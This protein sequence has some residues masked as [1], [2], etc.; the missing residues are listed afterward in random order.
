MLCA[1][2]MVDVHSA[3]CLHVCSVVQQC[4]I[5]MH[6]WLHAWLHGRMAAAS[7]RITCAGD[8]QGRLPL[9]VHVRHHRQALDDGDVSPAA[10]R[11]HQRSGHASG[12]TSHHR[13]AFLVL[14]RAAGRSDVRSVKG[15]SE[16]AVALRVLS[17]LLL[18]VS[19]GGVLVWTEAGDDR[20]GSG[21]VHAMELLWQPE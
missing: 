2:C 13:H 11:Q 16:L 8:H 7:H 18:L 19:I 20:R 17:A 6:A 5:S 9:R 3:A 4:T 15:V 10:L 12:A 14:Q 1:V 21:C